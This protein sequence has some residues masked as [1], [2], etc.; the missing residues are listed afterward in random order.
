MITNRFIHIHVP[1]TGG[2]LTRRVINDLMITKK[3]VTVVDETAHLTL[4]RSMERYY[5]KSAPL[6][7]TNSTPP[8]RSFAFVRNPFDWYVSQYHRES[9]TLAFSGTFREFFCQEVMEKGITLTATWHRYTYP[10][11]TYIGRFENLVDD[12][13]KIF[14]TLMPEVTEIN[15]LNEIKALGKVRESKERKEYAKYYDRSLINR[16]YCLDY[17]YLQKFHYD[18]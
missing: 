17:W 6:L 12:I 2:S 5:T 1:R 7:G 4:V 14:H 15:I 16:V 11:V 13:V 18:F 3:L 9:E 10:G 8:P